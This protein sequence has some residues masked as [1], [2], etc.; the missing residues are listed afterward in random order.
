MTDDCEGIDTSSLLYW[1][2]FYSMADLMKPKK[3]FLSILTISSQRE[4]CEEI[5]GANSGHVLSLDS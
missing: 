5:P 4:T 3:I 1:F 2:L